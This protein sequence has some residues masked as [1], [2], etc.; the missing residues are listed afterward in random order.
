M[1]NVRRMVKTVWERLD[2]TLSCNYCMIS[3]LPEWVLFVEGE[4]DGEDCMGAASFCA[5]L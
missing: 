5:F 4:V 1:A 2:S 3:F